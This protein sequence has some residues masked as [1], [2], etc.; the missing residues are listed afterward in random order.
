MTNV[1]LRTF[2][3]SNNMKVLD[4]LLDMN[5][6]VSVLDIC[7]GAELSRKTVEKILEKFIAQNLVVKTRKIGKT[8]MF[9]LNRSNH[10]V[11][12][13]IEINEFVV[14]QQEDILQTRLPIVV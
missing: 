14:K 6:D 1:F 4:Y 12:K 2:G 10:I 9:A 8:A 7:D 13:L 3:Q 11:Q 5:L